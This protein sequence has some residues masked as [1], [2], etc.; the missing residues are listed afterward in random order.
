MLARI[1]ALS[2]ADWN[3]HVRRS[4]LI[5]E[6]LVG[7]GVAPFGEMAA[8]LRV[9]AHDLAGQIDRAKQLT[10]TIDPR[11][12]GIRRDVWELCSRGRMVGCAH[13]FFKDMARLEDE[14]RRAIA[15]GLK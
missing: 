6:T 7:P 4:D 2:S 1:N 8:A 3:A 13:N 15:E 9:E 14:L 12:L 5:F 10:A 11:F